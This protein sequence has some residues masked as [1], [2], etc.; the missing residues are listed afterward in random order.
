G[1]DAHRG[2]NAVGVEVVDG[3]G[4]GG[5]GLL[6]AADCAFPARGY[7]VV[8]VG[9]GAVA[10]H[11][12]VNLGAARQGAVPPLDH[13][14]AA[15]AGADEAVTLGVVGAGGLFRGVVVLGGQRAHGVEQHGLAPVLLF[16]ATGKDHVLLAHLDLLHGRADAV[17]AGGTG[18]GDGIV[19]ALDLERG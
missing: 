9:G 3:A 12:G 1:P 19:D 6:H 8:A 2:G 15:A 11:F 4:G 5:Q 17:R 14:P 16:T 10:N 13:D 7:H 18:G